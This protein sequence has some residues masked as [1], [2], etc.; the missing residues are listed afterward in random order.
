MALGGGT[1]VAEMYAELG[2]RDQKY[3]SGMAAAQKQAVIFAGQVTGVF[4]QLRGTLST[5]VA[6]LAVRQVAGFFGEAISQ[7][8]NYQD[9]LN[10]TKAVL[11]GSADI[12]ISE[13]DRMADKLG[14]VKSEYLSAASSFAAS[15]KGAGFGMEE[16]A[17]IGNQLT[18]LGMDL[19]SFANTTNE[20]AFGALQAALRGEFDPIERYNVFISAAKIETEA[21]SMGLIKNKKELD[22]HAKRMTALSLIMK[23]TKD[24]QNDLTNTIDDQNNATKRLGGIWTNFT[25]ELGQSLQPAVAAVLPELTKMT[26]ELIDF[27]KGHQDEIKAM[28][29]V[30]GTDLVGALQTVS[31]LAHQNIENFKAMSQAWADA[32]DWVK[33]LV[34][35]PLKAPGAIA[36]VMDSVEG[37]IAKADAA[38][39]AARE[40][41][42]GALGGALAGLGTFAGLPGFDELTPKAGGA[43][44]MTEGALVKLWKAQAVEAARAR[45]RAGATIFG[46]APAE[47]LNPFQAKQLEVEARQ[48]EEER[49]KADT[50]TLMDRLAPG[51]PG[52]AKPVTGL[53]RPEG[54]M[55]PKERKEAMELDRIPFG[56]MTPE[57]QVE[58]L[59]KQR[60]TIEGL[61][62]REPARQSQLFTEGGSM[63]QQFQQRI[64]EQTD[65]QDEA[66]KLLKKIDEGIAK[67]NETQLK[68]ATDKGY[69]MIAPAAAARR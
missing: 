38:E 6:A 18:K 66:N 11:K 40:R 8:A 55:T 41:G 15:F 13:S 19:A 60:G 23:Q 31:D 49:R 45:D 34:K 54:M 12:V 9:V 42:R 39:K 52:L 61:M 7:A 22:D 65:K 53:M 29:Q 14:V 48:R 58:A 62:P 10:R 35:S 16:A 2:L 57:E 3:Y 43:P 26:G 51:V 56:E 68:K 37:R 44:R 30:I 28:A 50:Q 59:R 17:N 21:F 47:P 64:L 4:G 24:A 63:E 33:D 27:A 36:G 1:K 20:D 46:V 69:A 67:L 25:T 5:I 32:P